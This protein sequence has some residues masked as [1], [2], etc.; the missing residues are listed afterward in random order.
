[1]E[2]DG[3]DK[4]IKISS[5]WDELQEKFTQLGNKLDP[6][7]VALQIAGIYILLGS[8]WILLSDKVAESIIHDKET[9]I[10]VSVVKGWAYVLATGGL[11][12][13]LI[14]SALKRIYQDGQKIIQA[15]E[16][17]TSTY[18]EMEAAHEELTASE[19]ELRQQFDTLTESQRQ[20]TESE[21]RY[22]LILEASNDGI[23][24]EQGDKRHF[25]GRW[26]EITGYTQEELDRI[27]DWKS[28][29]HPDD[30][31][32]VIE[33]VEEHKRKKTPYYRCEYRFRAKNGRYIWIQTRGKAV[34]DEA[35][36]VHRMSGS[37]TD[38]TEL[39]ASQEQL[40]HM[41]YYDSL[42]D[43]PNRLALYRDLSEISVRSID[44]HRA[45]FFIDLDNFKYV[46]DSMG[47]SFGDQLIKR[48]G[49]KLEYLLQKMGSVYRLGGD[50]FIVVTREIREP[51]DVEQM[52][53]HILAGF[54]KPIRIGDSVAHINIS[55]GI[56][57]YP[58]HGNDTDALLRCA[59]IAMY[60]AKEAGRN[61]YVFY[62]QPMNE[63]VAERVLLEKH[64]RTAL[65]NNEFE[66]LYQP[67]FDLDENRV[68]G[69]EA[70]LRWDSRELGRISPLKFIRIAEET[71]LIM[72]LG[73]WAMKKACAFIKRLHMQGMDNL[74]VSV[75]I[76]M[77]QLLQK[78]FVDSVQEVLQAYD[79]S[80]RCLEL[81]ITESMLMESYEAIE[82]KLEL[83]RGRGVKIALDDFGKGYSSLSYLKELPITT[84]KIDK[85]FIDG[86]SSKE[87]SKSLT[88]Q[89]VLMGRNL[90]LSVVAEGVETKEQLDYLTRYKCHKIQ[91]YYFSEPLSEKEA[92]E[93][94]KM[95]INRR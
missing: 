4:E 75:N 94:V 52:A 57:L 15:Y 27:G 36:N 20:L 28:L 89:I 48:A 93:Y 60:K 24:D 55:I 21:E 1:M 25:S 59:D 12:F 22:R 32:A 69:F 92:E 33:A 58:E 78:D 65:E 73:I 19:E 11:F 40:H 70:L 76:S 72:P 23:W 26:F 43:L 66:L 38:I 18:E 88:G 53:S 17:L 81:E 10:L 95:D 34:F 16:E 80:P 35:G 85:S 9:L 29:I 74:E 8:L 6:A 30:H 77:L 42:A 90:G 61:R 56:A 7:G 46:N 49:E 82:E 68:T 54:K 67:Q 51:E 45:L 64:L 84:L 44:T 47:H 13:A 5:F 83:L 41:A 86:I 91:G 14:Y 3:H 39:K 2:Q 87:G 37:H 79:L 71:R 63:M 50:E 62:T 31:G